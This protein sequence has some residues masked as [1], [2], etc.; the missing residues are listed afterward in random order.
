MRKIIIFIL[1][2]MLL[3]GSGMTMA[4]E[5]GGGQAQPP[6]AQTQPSAPTMGPPP[7]MHQMQQTLQKMQDMMSQGKMTPEAM[8]EMQGMVNQMQG[9]VTQMQNM[10]QTGP[11]M[12]RMQP[13]QPQLQKQIDEL[14]QRVEAL[15]GQARGTKK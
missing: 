4:Q 12:N 2:S 15:E 5:K 8:K 10:V 1:A 3:I 11:M 13:H 6:Q 7:M 14:R 9:M